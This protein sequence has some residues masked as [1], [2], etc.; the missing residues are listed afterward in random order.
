MTFNFHVGS[1]KSSKSR[2]IKVKMYISFQADKA[3]DFL[4]KIKWYGNSSNWFL[5]DFLIILM[6]LQ[7]SVQIYAGSYPVDISTV[8]TV[9]K[10]G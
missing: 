7:K 2:S 5:H 10:N 6:R 9:I 4:Y 8:I 3:S 1:E